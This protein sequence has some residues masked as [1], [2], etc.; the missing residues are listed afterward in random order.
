[1]KSTTSPVVHVDTHLSNQGTILAVFQKIKRKPS[2][3][4][5]TD[6]LRDKNKME[7]SESSFI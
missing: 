6:T 5:G 3:E 4:K 1:M 7:H 2:P